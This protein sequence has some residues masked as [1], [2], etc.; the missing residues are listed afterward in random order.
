MNEVRKVVAYQD[1]FE[2]FLLS[3]TEKVQDKILKVITIIETMER[4]PTKYLKIIHD[5]LYEARIQLGSNIWRI[6]CF[7]DNGNLIVLLNWFQKKTQKT[8]KQEI[9]KAIS[10]M[11]AYY[12]EKEHGR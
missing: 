9:K 3:Q 5:G 11:N 12:K 2:K 10:L 8:P 7:F 6:F 4:V 1:H